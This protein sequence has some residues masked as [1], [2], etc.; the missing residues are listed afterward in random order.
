MNAHSFALKYPAGRFRKWLLPVLVC[1]AAVPG[2]A[3]AQA[4]ETI[5]NDPMR[6]Y[7][8][9]IEFDVLRNGE[10][11]GE[12]VT[13]FTRDDDILH[14]DHRFDVTVSFFIFNFSY[15]Y[16][17]GATWRNCAL[18]T[19]T[20]RVDDDGEKTEVRAQRT[21]DTLQIDGPA[22]SVEAD[23]PVFPTHHWHS[24]VLKQTRVLNTITGKVAQVS[25]TPVAQEMVETESGP[26]EATR[27]AYSGDLETQV[28][29]D[30][31]GRWV[32]MAFTGT[33]GSSIEYVCRRC[34]GAP[35][36]GAKPS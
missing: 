11:V 3:P 20:A 36:V 21:G 26:V 2:G 8:K 7:G 29:Y 19:L 10:P 15:L 13:T 30:G 34:Q 12:H 24:G 31:L 22:G 16:T 17:A 33:D 5:A 32:K 27:Y 35:Q 25:I 6:L 9:T 14:V 1:V 18:Q 28:W 23:E 4:C